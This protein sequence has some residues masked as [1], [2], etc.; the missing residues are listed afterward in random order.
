M[1][2]KIDDVIAG[3]IKTR[4]TIDEIK[5]AHSMQLAPYKAAIEKMESYLLNFLNVSGGSSFQAKGIGTVFKQDVVSCSV[6]DWDA[7]LAWIKANSAWEFLERR[8]SKSVVQEFAASQGQV[9]PGVDITTTI[10]VRVRKS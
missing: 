1:A 2:I 4:N 6:K 3:Y 10:E 9:P 8:V 5:E 7:T